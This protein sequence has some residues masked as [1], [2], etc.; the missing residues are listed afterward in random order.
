MTNTVLNRVCF[1]GAAAYL[2]FAVPATAGSITV[3]PATFA[4]AIAA[5][6]GGDTLRLVGTFG[7]IRIVNRDFASAV[8]INAAQ[9]TFTGTVTI[10]NV[11]NLKFGGGTFDIAGAPAFTKAV[12]VYGGRNIGFNALTVVGTEGGEGVVFNGTTGASVTS[13][14]FS[15]LQVGVVFGSV[16]NGIATRN[17]ITH[18]VSDGIDIANSHG[19]TASYNS[20]SNGNP[21]AGVH[22]D[23]VQLWSITGAPLQSNIIVRNNTATGPTQGFTAFATMGGELRVQILNNF[24]NTSYS[25]GV[26]CYECVY[27]NISYNRLKTQ[28]GATYLTNLNIIGG[29]SNS[30]IGNYVAPYDGPQAGP[31]LAALGRA[32]D[33][34][35]AIDPGSDPVLDPGMGDT[36]DLAELVG[37][38]PEGLIA[39]ASVPEP[40]NWALLIAGF[41]AVGIARRRA[42][43]E[44]ATG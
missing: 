42:R 6:R 43:P 19:V 26:A 15:G 27:S 3:T 12:T 38:Q 16:T 8:T 13:S 44:A 2:L 21:G 37:P 32:L 17:T 24:V 30:V 39:T 4:S 22:P 1:A 28:P 7:A 40:A 25:Q 34:T 29:S 9:A 31:H 33:L 36:P 18:S 14:S 10:G 5:A 11:S 23:C 35:P 20:C 41:A